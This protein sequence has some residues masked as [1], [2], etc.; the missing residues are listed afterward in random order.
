MLTQFCVFPS[1]PRC[2][3]SGSHS[4]ISISLE[5]PTTCNYILTLE[6]EFICTLLEETDELGQFVIPSEDLT[7]A[8]KNLAGSASETQGKI[9]E[10]KTEGSGGREEE[11]SENEKGH[12]SREDEREM[13]EEERENVGGGMSK[14]EVQRS[15]G[16]GLDTGKNLEP[17]DM[18]IDS[19]S[20]KQTSS[21][22]KQK[23]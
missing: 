6:A 7:G 2:S 5:E 12:G 11:E 1:L 19:E 15:E 4:Q 10:D 16:Y 23:S 22:K 13:E 14:M 18:N 8:E 9:E 3:T 17:N 20:E 21:K